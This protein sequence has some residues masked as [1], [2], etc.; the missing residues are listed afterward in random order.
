MYA[1]QESV[2]G[3][4]EPGIFFPTSDQLRVPK[5]VTI[6]TT[7]EAEIAR[8]DVV[9]DTKISAYRFSKQKRGVDIYGEVM[10]IIKKHSRQKVSPVEWEKIGGAVR[11]SIKNNF[12]INFAFLWACSGMARSAMKF[13]QNELNFPRLGDVWSLS[14][15]KTFNKKIEESYPPGIKMLI[16]DELPLLQLLGWKRE[17]LLKR[18]NVMKKIAERMCPGIIE[19]VDMPSFADYAGKIQPVN[20]SPEEILSIIT[21]QDNHIPTQVSDLLYTQREKPWD[22]I[23]ACFPAVIWEKA[24]QTRMEMARIGQARKETG[25]VSDCFSGMPYIDACI[26]EKG[27]WCPDIWA[28]AFPQHGGTVLEVDGRARYSIQIAPEYRL[29]GNNEP[30]YISTSEFNRLIGR[31]APSREFIFY[32]KKR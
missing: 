13:V 28:M 30:V 16:V 26:V 8:M 3:K 20:P 32:W 6:R 14:W 31:I 12:P 19:I 4:S 18:H 10:Q 5:K 23:R 25:Y 9:M 29:M 2:I 17:E 27:R 11:Y 15:I 1:Q 7:L 22:E 21:S 24:R